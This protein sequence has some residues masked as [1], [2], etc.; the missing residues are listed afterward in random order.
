[1]SQCLQIQEA[2]TDLEESI[3]KPGREYQKQ[4]VFIKK[5]HINHQRQFFVFTDIM[6]VTNHNWRVKDI[7]DI[8]TVDIKLKPNIQPLKKKKSFRFGKLK[9]KENKENEYVYDDNKIIEKKKKIPKKK[10]QVK[11]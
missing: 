8:R 2:L 3:V 9:N 7:L 1:M 4:F 10:K 5:G 11:Q 6:I